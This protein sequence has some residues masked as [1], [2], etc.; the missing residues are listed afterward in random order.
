[1]ILKVNRT[2]CRRVRYHNQKGH[3]REVT[4]AEVTRCKNGSD[5]VIYRICR[6]FGL[7]ER[8]LENQQFPKSSRVSSVPPT[9]LSLLYATVHSCYPFA[10]TVA[11]SQRLHTP[12]FT[13]LPLSLRPSLLPS[14]SQ[15]LRTTLSSMVR[16]LS[17]TPL[18]PLSAPSSCSSLL[19][20]ANNQTSSFY[21]FTLLL[22][23]FHLPFD[24]RGPLLN[25]LRLLVGV[26]VVG[27]HVLFVQ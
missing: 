15:I 27:P 17:S 10:L 25:W 14:A 6:S 5:A 23:L 18:S 16:S 20:K 11:L 9:L 3:G 4:P 7:G 12:L 21:R 13:S 8:K 19:F 24:R 2:H 26:L 1:M 22:H